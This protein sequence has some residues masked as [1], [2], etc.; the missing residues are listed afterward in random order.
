MLLQVHGGAAGSVLKTSRLSCRRRYPRG[1]VSMVSS[2]EVPMMS[3]IHYRL[4]GLGRT[5]PAR[6]NNRKFWENVRRADIFTGPPRHWGGGG[7]VYRF[8][9]E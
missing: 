1:L 4:Q 9:G 3:V 7:G 6:I 8:P 5:R 2:T